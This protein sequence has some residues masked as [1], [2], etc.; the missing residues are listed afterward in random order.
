MNR[1]ATGQGPA[2]ALETETC[3]RAEPGGT[4]TMTIWNI[5]AWFVLA[6]IVPFEVA[7][8]C[9]AAAGRRELSRSTWSR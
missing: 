9:C 7:P 1:R 6:G 3:P 2:P 5:A 4:V 8:L